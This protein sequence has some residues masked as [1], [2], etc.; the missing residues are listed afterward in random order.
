VQVDRVRPVGR[1]CAIS[2]RPLFVI[3]GSSD[4]DLP[5]D[6]ACRMYA[7]ACE[8]E[9]L[10]IIA[11]A[12]HPAYAST[13]GAEFGRQLVSFFEGALLSGEPRPGR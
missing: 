5:R 2:P 12:T 3:A 11:H 13:A 4:R 1:L 8:P 6:V 9:R 7:A 10:W